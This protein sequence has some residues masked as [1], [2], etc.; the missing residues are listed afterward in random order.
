MGM[1]YR[2]TQG[3]MY[4]D[5][6]CTK[7][8]IEESN[9]IITK[10]NK[11]HQLKNTLINLKEFKNDLDNFSAPPNEHGWSLSNLPTH[12]WETLGECINDIEK[13]INEDKKQ[14]ENE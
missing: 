8:C 3:C 6:V 12:F 10:M 2:A 11:Q 5:G 13:Y 4:C 9:N 14:N 7:E 1:I